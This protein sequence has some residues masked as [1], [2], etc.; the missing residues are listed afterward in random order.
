MSK[1]TLKD[2]APRT[3]ERYTRAQKIMSDVADKLKD[4]YT[5][6]Y[7][8]VFFMHDLGSD[9]RMLSEHAARWED[10]CRK[11]GQHPFAWTNEDGSVDTR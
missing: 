9:L 5:W 11:T 3:L 8:A 1:G 2:N 10:H 4:Y 7:Y 6:N